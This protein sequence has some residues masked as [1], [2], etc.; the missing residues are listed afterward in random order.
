M[1]NIAAL[2]AAT[3]LG[4]WVGTWAASPS[5]SNAARQFNQETLREIVHASVGGAQVRVRLSNAFGAQ[6]LMIGAAH[7]AI[8]TSGTSIAQ[9]RPLTFSGQ[10]AFSI[11]PGALALSDPVSLEVTAFSDLAVSIYLPGPTTGA[12]VHQSA[13]QTSYVVPGDLTGSASLP[14]SAAKITSWQFLAGVDVSTNRASEAIVAFGD[15]ITDG[16]RST[17]DANARW[18]DVLARR[19]RSMAVLNAGIG[20]NRVLHDGAAQLAFAG[21]SALARF[22]RDVL[23]QPGVK[24]VI[25]LE[26]INDIGIPGSVAAGS[27][28]VT[29]K[30]IIAG[31]RQLIERA[32]ENGLRIFGGTLTPFEGTTIPNYYSPERETKRQAVNEWI[33][34]SKSFDAVIDFDKAVQD[35]EHPARMLPKYDCGDHLHMSDAGYKAMGEAIDL[36]LFGAKKRK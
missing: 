30:E 3:S 17:N 22:D 4:S 34:T 31:L 32:H 28:E 1:L 24:Y 33:R 19:L 10:T 29:P 5:S 12:T 27:E 36:G 16:A 26:G 6:P 25:V 13:Q 21:Q 8:R 2:L 20:G 14:E 18:P 11:P 7:V 15:S 35:P 23:A 9:D